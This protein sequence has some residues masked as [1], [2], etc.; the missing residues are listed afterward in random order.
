MEEMVLVLNSLQEDSKQCEEIDGESSKSKQP[1]WVKVVDRGGLF[2]A[3]W[4]LTYFYVQ[5][6]LP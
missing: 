3:E 1:N 2:I 4:N 6:K 5:L